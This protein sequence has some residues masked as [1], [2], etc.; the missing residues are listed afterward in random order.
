MDYGIPRADDLPM[1]E[2]K[3]N[4]VPSPTNPLGIKAGGEGGT[5]GALASVANAVID[6]LK[7]YG[8][9]DI[10]M[11]ITPLKVWTEIDRKKV[12]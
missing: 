3:L 6:A 11:P 7:P 2:T 9:R 8:V 5:T 1:F 4:E 10:K 12:K